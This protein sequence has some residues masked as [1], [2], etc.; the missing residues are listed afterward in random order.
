MDHRGIL[1][2]ILL[3]LFAFEGLPAEETLV[4]TVS[5]PEKSQLSASAV[6]ELTLPMAVEMALER[7]PL[8]RASIAGRE[9][10]DAHLNK[11]QAKRWFLLQF[12]ETYTYS[13]NPVFVFGSLL[14]QSR[15]GPGNF[16][17]DSLN[18]PDPLSN[19]R[20]ALTLRIP[21]F[22]QLE[23]GSGIDQ[24]KIGQE[25][26]D[27][28]KEA[29]RQQIRFEVIR[30]F[31]G[32]LVARARKDVADEAVKTADEEVKRTRNLFSKG[33][34]VRSDLLAAQVQLAEFQQQQAQAAGDLAVANAA[35]NIALS[36]P[37]EAEHALRG[38]LAEKT[39]EIPGIDQ[40]ISQA[41]AHRPDYA[42]RNA[43]VLSAEKRIR[44]ARGLYLPRIDFFSTYGISSENLSSGSSD[45]AIGAGLTYNLFDSGRKAQL[46]EAR[47]A[48]SL[49]AAELE[50]LANQI[51]LEVVKAYQQYLSAQSRL[52][53][54]ARTVDQAQDALRIVRDRYQEGLTI[55]TEVLRAQTALVR[56]RL[57]LLA[58][59][60]DYYMGFAQVLKATGRLTDIQPFLF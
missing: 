40:L 18:N 35:L 59:R 25:Q 30:S 16:E 29:M 60:Y 31:F 52:N 4:P 24:A 9:I 50:Q 51:H 21:I 23:A 32:V 58:A 3:V 17:I 38:R 7:H 11:A 37:V 49:A 28:Q 19:F 22:D 53:L 42:R 10:A 6:M 5:K 56:S 47:A 33:I 54:A 8:I 20:T 44:G 46:G 26:A 34:V 2:G 39:F 41:L 36:L 55:I 43:A 27:W 48:R 14:E 12:S 1:A 45:Y 15:F 13:N 57:H